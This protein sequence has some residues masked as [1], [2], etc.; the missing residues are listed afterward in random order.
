MS[1]FNLKNGIKLYYEDKGKGRP[2]IMMHGWTSSHVI[3]S[4][5]VEL[6][7]DN[8]RFITYDHRGHGKSFDTSNEEATM[9]ALSDDLNELIEGLGLFDV[10]LL[11]W[12]MGA[13][14]AM[15][16]IRRY[17]CSALKQVILCDM[18]PKLINDSEWNLGL[19]QGKYTAQDMN[20]D[21]EKDF[22]NLYQDFTEG[23][24]PTLQ[25]VPEVILRRRLKGKLSNSDETVLRSLSKSM[26]LQ[27]N[28]DVIEKITVPL[29][30]FYAVPG[31]LFSPDL[32]KWYE[33][34]TKVSF[35][36]VAFPRSTH[37]FIA[38]HP[39]RFANELKK[40]L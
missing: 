37:M 19:Y 16:Y 25:K 34:N 13:C 24:V 22:L 18:T 5:P 3:Y 2:V 33:N 30:Y 23:T 39:R 14:V 8:A 10:T 1:E 31:S 4:L 6:L 38:E 26:K 21:E 9:E 20:R 27:D 35:N 28:R 40:L 11:G 29:T 36:S 17:G 12:S 7:K 15:N 32:A